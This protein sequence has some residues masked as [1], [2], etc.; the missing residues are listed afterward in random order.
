MPSTGIQTHGFNGEMAQR[1]LLGLDAL[2][3]YSQEIMDKRAKKCSLGYLQRIPPLRISLALDCEPKTCEDPDEKTNRE[4]PP[5]ARSSRYPIDNDFGKAVYLRPFTAPARCPA[6]DYRSQGRELKKCPKPRCISATRRRCWRSEV[7]SVLDL[8]TL[9]RMVHTGPVLSSLGGASLIAS[10]RDVVQESKATVEKSDVPVCVDD[11]RPEKTSTDTSGCSRAQDFTDHSPPSRVNTQNTAAISL[12]IED[13]MKNPDNKVLTV[14][15]KTIS[16]HVQ[17]VSETHPII[18][19]NHTNNLSDF[20]RN[21]IIRSRTFSP[22]GASP[23]LRNR[24]FGLQSAMLKKS[25]SSKVSSS[26][27]T[28]VILYYLSADGTQQRVKMAKDGNVTKQKQVNSSETRKNFVQDRKSIHISPTIEQKD[29]ERGVGPVING[30]NP[31][32]S[33][34]CGPSLHASSH[35]VPR[36][37]YPS[38]TRTSS[39]QISRPSSVREI[40][41]WSYVS[42]SKPLSPPV[43]LE[44][45]LQKKTG[46]NASPDMVK[47]EVMPTSR[48]MFITKSVILENRNGKPGCS[49][50]EIHS[51]G[52]YLE[53]VRSSEGTTEET[54][55]EGGG[56]REIKGEIGQI[57]PPPSIELLEITNSEKESS[58]EQVQKSP[59][60][61]VHLNT[62][63]IISIPTATVDSAD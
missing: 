44:E 38:S 20:Q 43:I 16:A 40:H 41:N 46:G 32:A 27:N 45:P 15:Q 53:C 9:C 36:L 17:N 11:F 34:D 47:D 63:P 22:A 18:Y 57:H 26:D 25:K 14:R 31:M 61:P 4:K 48:V 35:H 52:T 29:K 13:E 56:T 3:K 54:K 33:V 37:F 19:N 1:I 12:C 28:K 6:N 8:D 58:E 30:M 7:E 49:S 50:D 51:G 55:M 23:L 60:I 10:P 42:I 62:T 21:L 5:S 39:S 24:Q 2:D 59:A